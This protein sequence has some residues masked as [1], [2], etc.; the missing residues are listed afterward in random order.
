MSI[1]LHKNMDPKT[2]ILPNEISKLLKCNKSIVNVK[3]K[4]TDNVG[5]S[6]TSKAIACWTTI[7][8]IHL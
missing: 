4:T 3:A 2:F 7:K 8:L 5:T 6:G 1:P